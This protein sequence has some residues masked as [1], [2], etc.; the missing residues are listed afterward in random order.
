MEDLRRT[1]KAKGKAVVEEPDDTINVEEE[2][3][4][5]DFVDT[6][7]DNSGK[8]EKKPKKRSRD[9]KL[10]TELEKPNN[11]TLGKDKRKLV[12]PNTKA[13]TSKP[14]SEKMASPSKPVTVK[15]TATQFQSRSSPKSLYHACSTLRPH[16]KACLEQI[17]FGGL[18]DFKMDGITSRLGLYVVD[19]L[20]V[21]E[22]EIKLSKG[23][24]RIT[25]DLIAEM[26]GIENEGIDIEAGEAKRDENMVES[27]TK[28]YE[29]V[30]DIKPADVKY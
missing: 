26:L 7:W 11:S 8:N 2:E 14:P 6:A 27:W 20:D 13:G 1:S 23:S 19:K 25:K 16:Q 18:V 9:S 17:G 12:I 21:K 30:K 5:D 3:T 28:Q 29:G 22:M 4:D 24:I 15:I 10:L